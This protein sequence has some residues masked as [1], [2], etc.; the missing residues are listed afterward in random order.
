MKHSEPLHIDGAAGEGGGQVLRSSL[1]LS[2]L[3]GRPLYI[4]NIRANRSKPGLS[5]QHL[6]ALKAASAICDASLEGAKL[7][8]KE[9]RFTPGKILPGKYK[10]DI[11]TAGA[12]SLVLQ[13]VFLPLALAEK[14]SNL[15]IRGGT[16]VMWSPTFDYLEAQ[17]LHFIAQIG[18]DAKLTLKNAGFFPKGGGTI[19]TSI[20]P[21]G[22]I[23]PLNLTQRGQL[24]RIRGNACLANLD[25][26][27]ARRMKLQALRKLQPICR[28]TK[29]KTVKIPSP[30]PGA[31]ITLTAQF[32]HGRCCYTALGKKGKRAEWVAD[33]AAENILDFIQADGAFDE[34][35][36]DQIMLPLA[37]ADGPS[38]FSTNKITQHLLTNASIIQQF[39]PIKIMVHGEEGGSGT[40]TIDPT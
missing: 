19:Y 38:A 14:S 31:C 17:W 21:G 24:I 1:T 32:E 7:H 34:H 20:R 35:M 39:L 25:I 6:T 22:M 2:I 29:I 10:F 37:F 15:T 28:D 3:T 33:E 36:A 12:T 18:L 27:I 30:N 4:T 16:H 8:S 11:R 26:D 9:V 23:T 40:I 5:H 13:T